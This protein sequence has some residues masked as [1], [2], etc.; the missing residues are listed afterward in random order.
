MAEW[1]AVPFLQFIQATH[2]GTVKKL[3]KIKKMLAVKNDL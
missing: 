1:K 3:K 2:R